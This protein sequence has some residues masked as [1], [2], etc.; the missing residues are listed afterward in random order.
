M[1]NLTFREE[2]AFFRGKTAGFI[3]EDCP[4]PETEEEI[5]SLFQYFGPMFSR[6]VGCRTKQEKLFFAAV[7]VFSESYL[8]EAV[9][10][11]PE[12]LNEASEVT[13]LQKDFFGSPLDELANYFALGHG[14]LNEEDLAAKKSRLTL[15]EIRR[16]FDAKYK[17][18]EKADAASMEQRMMLSDL[19]INGSLPMI[20]R[21]EWENLTKK[22]ADELIRGIITKQEG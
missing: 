7:S 2:E 10:R 13:P 12:M 19:I 1:M 6:I 15:P 3:P 14:I 11:L 5:D 21:R 17:P 9:R 8:D 4:L 16:G 20:D 22:D 18:E